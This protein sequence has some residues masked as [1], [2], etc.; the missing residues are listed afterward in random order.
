[1]EI[2]DKLGEILQRKK[3]NLR[4]SCDCGNRG[5]M[6]CATAFEMYLKLASANVPIK[7][8]DKTIDDL[9]EANGTVKAKVQ[10]YCLK[11]PKVLDRGMGLFLVGSNGVGK[12]LTASIIL[13]EAL[14]Q[15]FSAR[16]TTLAEILTMSSDGMYD[17]E[18]RKQYRRELIEVD[19]LVIDD[20]TKTYKNT[21]K[22]SSTY[23]DTQFDYLFRTRANANLPV[24]V[25]SNHRRE[26]ALKSADETL[27]NSLLSLFAEH[28][29][30]ITFLGK[31]RRIGNDRQQGSSASS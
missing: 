10:E 17:Q 20:I 18:A 23:I 6:K 27:S 28:L 7:Y 25:T 15:K 30:D 1:M 2:N 13:R 16:F 11:L 5:C 4:A 29:K 21:D 9:D 24:I 14:H 31:D 19:F 12:T 8:W 3:V 22:Q 26:D